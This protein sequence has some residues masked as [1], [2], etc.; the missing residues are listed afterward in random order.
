VIDW[1][2][3]CKAAADGHEDREALEG[4]I[5]GKWNVVVKG[6]AVVIPVFI[7]SPIPHYLLNQPLPVSIL[8]STS[9]PSLSSPKITELLQRAVPAD[10]PNDICKVIV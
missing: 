5:E 4:R 8:I 6:L 7:H 2:I 9:I 10:L 1:C 3:D